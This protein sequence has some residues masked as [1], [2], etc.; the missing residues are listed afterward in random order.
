MHIRDM[1]IGYARV[2]TDDQD[3]RLQRAAAH[4]RRHDAMRAAYI[5]FRVLPEPGGAP[6]VCLEAGYTAGASLR[7]GGRSTCPLSHSLRDF[8]SGRQ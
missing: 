1:L 5:S 6:P 8:R 3:L 2:S 7:Q 4:L